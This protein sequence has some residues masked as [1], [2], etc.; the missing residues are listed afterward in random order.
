M[1]VSVQ[2]MRD[3]EGLMAFSH[4]A[5]TLIPLQPLLPSEAPSVAEAQRIEP[6]FLLA[7][8][9][10]IWGFNSRPGRLLGQQEVIRLINLGGKEDKMTHL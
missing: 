10:C 7:C 6:G 2:V 9:R 3:A 5:E 4:L 1:Q 8:K